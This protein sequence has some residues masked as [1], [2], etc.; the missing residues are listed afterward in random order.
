MRF[1]K[2][3]CHPVTL[4][5]TTKAERINLRTSEKGNKM[6]LRTIMVA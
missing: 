3:I 1:R 5:H 6:M 2:H 4:P